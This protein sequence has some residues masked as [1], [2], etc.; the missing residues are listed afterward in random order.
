MTMNRRHFF[1]RISGVLGGTALAELL[2]H[3]LPGGAVATDCASPKP[4][5]APKATSVI[6]LFM[7]GGPSQMDLLDPKPMLDKNH[8]QAYFK[9]IA[10][11][12]ENPQSAGA[13]MRSPFRFKK[14]GQCGM[15]VSDALPH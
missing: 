10:G 8:G 5:F 1:Q 4:H 9:H 11:E 12:V 15:W 7:N 6:H 14:H 2:R 3:D 13:L